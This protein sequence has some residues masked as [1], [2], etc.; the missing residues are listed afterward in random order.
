[1]N[2]FEVRFNYVLDGKRKA[3][4]LNG[5]SHDASSNVVAEHAEHA[6]NI[7][8]KNNV[9]DTFELLDDA[10]NVVLRKGKPVLQRITGIV[11]QSVEFV[12]HLD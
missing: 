12:R 8:K 5:R 1:M 7:V 10:G 2:V 4:E 11:V 9:G 3:A 6:I